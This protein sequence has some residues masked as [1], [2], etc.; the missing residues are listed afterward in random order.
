MSTWQSAKCRRM[1]RRHGTAEEDGQQLGISTVNAY[2]TGT[3]EAVAGKSFVA[4]DAQ[5]VTRMPRSQ[6]TLQEPA[7]KGRR[8]ASLYAWV[9]CVIYRGKRMCGLRTLSHAASPL[10]WR[11][12][13]PPLPGLGD[14]CVRQGLLRAR[15]PTGAL[16]LATC[17]CPS[18]DATRCTWSRMGSQ[19]QWRIRVPRQTE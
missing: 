12:C 17:V 8:L 3:G 18:N 13:C 9:G 1:P 7:H 16:S 4:V 19:W 14:R 11:C 5:R 2:G 6:Q 10:S 15:T